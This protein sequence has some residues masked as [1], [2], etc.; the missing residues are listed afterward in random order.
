MMMTREAVLEQLDELLKTYQPYTADNLGWLG[1]RLEELFDGDDG[2]YAPEIA[3]L[4]YMNGKLVA[5]IRAPEPE[6][7]AEEWC[8]AMQDFVGGRFE[9]EPYKPTASSTSSAAQKASAGDNNDEPPPG[10]FVLPVGRAAP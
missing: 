8:A 1:L 2:P 3:R 6:H 10:G 5:T 4:R 9:V 7:D